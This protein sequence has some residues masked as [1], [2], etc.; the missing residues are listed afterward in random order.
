MLSGMEKMF[1]KKIGSS[2][3]QKKHLDKLAKCFTPIDDSMAENEEKMMQS[4]D[5]WNLL[6]EHFSVLKEFL[7]WPYMN[8]DEI[9]E[10]NLHIK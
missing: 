3:I 1:V 10:A 6:V 4:T 7:L 9:R 8:Y 2:T 5:F